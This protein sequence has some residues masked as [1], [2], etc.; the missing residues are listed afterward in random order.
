MRISDWS[1][2]VCSSD[3][4]RS[5]P[6]VEKSNASF[7]EIDDVTGD[8]CH[9]VDKRSRS[10]QAV[11]FGLRVWYMERGTT[12]GDFG[13]DRDDAV[14]KCLE[15]IGFEPGA[16]NLTRNRIDALFCQD[17][18]FYLEDRSEEHTSELQSLMSI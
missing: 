7:F 6:W 3:L 5:D 18:L 16:Q 2:D 1:S 13:V 15:N 10:K 4:N 11:T 9:G 8:D 12:H 17:A 14:G